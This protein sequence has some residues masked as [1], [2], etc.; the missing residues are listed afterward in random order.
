LVDGDPAVRVSTQL[1]LQTAGI[2]VYAYSTAIE[3]L[4]DVHLQ[5]VKLL[6]IDVNLAGM[7]GIELLEQIRKENI[8][9]DAIFTTARGDSAG[10]RA[11]A[12]RTGAAV[13]LKP[14]K[15]DHLL[16]YLKTV[17]GDPEAS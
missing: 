5:G 12:A 7:T 15:P 16:A 14:F 13:L 10:L 4:S 6:V 1:L 9:A 8:T 2:E 17:L 11:A 3:F